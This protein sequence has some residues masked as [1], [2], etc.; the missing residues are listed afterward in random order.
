VIN[1]GV[2][3]EYA[4]CSWF[5]FVT[6]DLFGRR[7]LLIVASSIMAASMFVMGGI[8]TAYAQP[9]GHLANFLIAAYVIWIAIFASSWSTVV[10]PSN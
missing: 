2:F 9:T 10:G 1:V 7:Q 6:P 3:V 4:V 8:S 5:A